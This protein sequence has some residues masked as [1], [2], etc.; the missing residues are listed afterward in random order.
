MEI[1]TE[2]NSKAGSGAKNFFGQFGLFFIMMSYPIL[3]MIWRHQYPLLSAEVFLFFTS[4]IL[5]ALLF[6][7]LT[8]ACRPWLSNVIFAIN[9]S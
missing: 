9:P 8:A 6:A 4:I 1:F 7:V 2:R 3:S 5:I